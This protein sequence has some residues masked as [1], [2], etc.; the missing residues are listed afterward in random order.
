MVNLLLFLGVICASG[1]CFA[2]DPPGSD[3]PIPSLDQQYNQAK[4]YFNQL[5]N[6]TKLS[7]ERDNWLKGGQNFRRIYLSAPQSPLAPSCL[8]M[9]G[10]MYLEMFDRFAKTE[11]LDEA[12]SYFND[13]ARLFSDH[14]LADDSYYAIGQ[15]YLQNKKD[16]KQ[17]ALYFSKVVTDYP[18]GD[19]FGKSSEMLKMLSKEHD[20][21]LPR[22][23]MG[24]SQI[25]KLNYVL[26]VK[27]WSSQDYTRVV[28]VASGPV[29]Y[30]EELLEKTKD[31]PRRLYIDFKNSYIEPRYRAIVPIE[32]GLLRS[33]RTGQFSEDVVRVVLDIDTLDSY[34]IYSLPDPFRVV[35]D[36][37]GQALVANQEQQS[38]Q[39]PKLSSTTI[40]SSP[41]PVAPPTPA[42]PGTSPA[43]PEM[44]S[45][46]ADLT[47][48]AT[49]EVAALPP[50][51]DVTPPPPPFKRITRTQKKIRVQAAQAQAEPDSPKKDPKAKSL[52]LA[53][54]LG[55]GVKRIVLDPGHGGKDPGAIA[56]GIKEKDVVLAIA[57][58]LRPV[59]AKELGC[60]VIL[61]RNEDQFLSLEERTAI[62]NT[63]S[64]DLFISLHVNAHPSDKVRGFETYFLNLTTNAEAMRVAARENAT[65]TH[66]MSDLQ[67]IL[68]DILKN[69][70]IAESSRLAK[71]VHDAMMSGLSADNNFGK[72]KHLGVKQA[73]FYVLL[74]AQ[75]PAILI[76][77]AFISN[78]EDAE[79]LAS[80]EFITALSEQ[81]SLG[82]KSYINSITASL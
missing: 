63:N 55:L 19:L 17:A 59:L 75:M 39:P 38:K 42:T 78:K 40:D 47:A 29:N 81:I 4:F 37:R 13:T 50:P 30:R 53:Q 8:F 48:P 2:A 64:A 70:K 14:K 16:P 10:R 62:A 52:S 80:P 60:E 44:S 61:T 74:G 15:L 23:M 32:D 9:L 18:S 68:S 41:P 58:S 72:I 57:K 45:A 1:P 51:P 34:K 26:P 54:Q 49:P 65:S 79:N 21:P 3:G 5:G 66:Q 46:D 35:I 27:Y 11:D 76:E 43:L 6:N 69:S 25:D 67:D 24:S 22:V 56:N 82:I 73:P 77:I 7:L 12:I 33:I 36:V 28:I 20:I 71:Q 31:Q